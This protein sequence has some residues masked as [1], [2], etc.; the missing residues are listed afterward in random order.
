MSEDLRLVFGQ[1]GIVKKSLVKKIN[2]KSKLENKLLKK[3]A[4]LNQE[5]RKCMWHEYTFYNIKNNF[6]N[7]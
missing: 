5:I 4:F 6:L 1:R 7:F 2:D 3:D